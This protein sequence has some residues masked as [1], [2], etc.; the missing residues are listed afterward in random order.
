MTQNEAGQLFSTYLG[1]HNPVT[2]NKKIIYIF[3]IDTYIDP[4]FANHLLLYCSAFYKGM[5][6]SLMSSK[7]QDFFGKFKIKNRINDHTS[8]L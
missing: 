7:E 5:I 8:G 1:S 6:V 3:I 4:D 2:K